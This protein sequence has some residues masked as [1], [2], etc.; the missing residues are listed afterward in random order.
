[1]SDFREAMWGVLQQGVSTLD[2]DFREYA[3][4]HF[5]RLLANAATPRFEHALSEVAG[6]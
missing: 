3:A 2:F 1:M 5:D 4:E 6:A